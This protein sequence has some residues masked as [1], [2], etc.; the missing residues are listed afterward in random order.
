MEL[1]NVAQRAGG[2]G[3]VMTFYF[4]GVNHFDSLTGGLARH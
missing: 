2:P 1:Q 3:H 4:N